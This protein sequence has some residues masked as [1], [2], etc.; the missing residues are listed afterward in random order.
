MANPLKDYYKILGLRR[1]ATP[2]EIKR[3]FRKQAKE[4][5][6]DHNQGKR[7]EERFK[8]LN[9]A[10]ETLGDAARRKD[11]D[12]QLNG[13]A[14][15]SANGASTRTT[16]G[17]GSARGTESS[18][19][20][21]GSHLESEMAIT[22]EEAAR[23]ADRKITLAIKQTKFFGGAK[24][25]RK[26]FDVRIP[27][28]IRDGQKI[29]LKNASPGEE[30]VIIRIRVAPHARFAF[31]GEDLMTEVRVT[32]WEA[33]LGESIQVPTLEGTVS[34]RLMPGVRSGQKL[35]LKGQGFPI[36]SGGRGDLLYRVM[37]AVPNPLTPDERALFEK[38]KN[39][40]R[41]DPRA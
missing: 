29:R 3:A 13:A 12:A 20:G 18:G 30:D 23:G 11:Y 25:T 38:L 2:D 35:R 31:E 39:I 19:A 17:A 21:A 10:Y 37:I 15:S 8:E 41:F 16:P 32:P 9:E 28:G 1:S 22:L 5:H 36:K 40:S 6:P 33:A 24:E 7:A 4:V 27:P 14:N 34:L 26:T